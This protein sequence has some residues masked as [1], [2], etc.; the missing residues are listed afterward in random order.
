[1]H[2]NVPPASKQVAPFLHGEE[3]QILPVGKAVGL[4]VV[5]ELV[6]WVGVTVGA[7]VGWTSQW[8]PEKPAVQL[9]L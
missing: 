6:G 5:G 4:G 2:E 3:P 8:V 1:M 7:L 9:H